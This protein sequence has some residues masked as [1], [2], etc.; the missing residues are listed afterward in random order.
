MALVNKLI[1]YILI[2]LAV[3]L[4]A[5]MF[6]YAGGLMVTSGGS[7]ESRNKAKEIFINVGIGIFCI[8]GSWIIIHTIFLIF[9][10]SG[11]WIGL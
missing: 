8:A 9:G 3:P 10:Y 7:P 4:A 6:V 2:Y 5:I 1:N 11:S